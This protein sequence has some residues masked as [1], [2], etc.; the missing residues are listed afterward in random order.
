MIDTKNLVIDYKGGKQLT[1]QDIHIK[2]G[3]QWLLKGN[4]GTGKTSL[5][6]MLSGILTPT[7][8][9]ISLD[10]VLINQL[11][12]SEMDKYRAKSIGLI[13]QRNLFVSSLNMYNNLVITRKLASKAIKKDNIL[14]LT[15]ELGITEL[16]NK[17]PHELSQGEQQRFSIARSLINNPKVI[18]ADEPTSSLD[19]TNCKRFIDT[20]TNICN[21]HEVTLLIATHDN[22]FNAKFQNSIQLAKV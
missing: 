16:I 18:L 4:S 11:S 6:H 7:S 22:R 5:L 14:Q 3:Q 20:I 10:D 1:F 8:G 21:R 9:T 12:Q 19:D 13:F 15:S 17:M 2:K